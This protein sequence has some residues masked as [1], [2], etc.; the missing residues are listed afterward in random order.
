M[1]D[2]DDNEDL[3]RR[4]ARPDDGPIAAGDRLDGFRIIG[5]TFSNKVYWPAWTADRVLLEG[6]ED[7]GRAPKREMPPADYGRLER[8][9]PSPAENLPEQAVRIAPGHLKTDYGEA[10]EVLREGGLFIHAILKTMDEARHPTW[11]MGGAV[12]DMV[13][14]GGPGAE[15]NDLDF[16]GTMGPGELNELACVELRRNGVSQ[17]RWRVSDRLVC[18]LTPAVDKEAIFEYRPLNMPGFQIEVW[19]GDLASDAR[20]RDLTVNTLAYDVHE[21]LL[22]DPIGSG[23]EHLK[24]ERR[25]LDTPYTGEDPLQWAV[26]ILRAV[27]FRLRW[28]DSL[29]GALREKFGRLPAD[30]TA[31]VTD[32]RWALLRRLREKYVKPEYRGEAELRVAEQLGA[33]AVDLVRALQETDA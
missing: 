4:Y 5:F 3:R 15:L 19:G 22:I 7:L 26:L 8:T 10:V 20:T 17:Y 2:S 32:D 9:G 33:A 29:V 1:V 23:L 11:L 12:R 25:V 24:S 6:E 18:S 28:P 14:A 27:K 31:H 21:D 13:A 16:S 30:L